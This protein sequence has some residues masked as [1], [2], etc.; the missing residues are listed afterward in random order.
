[1]H[2]CFFSGL[3]LLS[4]AFSLH[5]TLA[6]VR[7]TVG[8]DLHGEPPAKMLTRTRIEGSYD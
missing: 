4:L 1:M 7:L 6:Y 8:T 3:L 2:L 5:L